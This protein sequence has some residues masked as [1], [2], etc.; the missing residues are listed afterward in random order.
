MSSENMVFGAVAGLSNSKHPSLLAKRLALA[1]LKESTLVP[2]N[3]LVGEGANSFAME[4]D[5]VPTCSNSDLI[6]K[7]SLKHYEKAKSIV[8]GQRW[9]TVGACS[10][11][12]HTSLI[13]LFKISKVYLEF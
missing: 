5:D 12:V 9:D 8:D 3:C 1:Q 7:K 6:T 13:C 2:P 10:I 11:K 4:C